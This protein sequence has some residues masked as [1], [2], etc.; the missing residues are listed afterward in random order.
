MVLRLIARSP[1]TGFVATVIPEKLTSQKLD[2]S[3][4]ASGPHDFAV[5]ISRARQLQLPR[6]P[7]PTAFR[8]DR[9]PPLLSGETRGE[10]PLICP[11]RQAEYFL[12]ADLTE[13]H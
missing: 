6:P 2:A 4:G 5:R 3:I 1:V 8:D 7:H 9:E 12:E 10:T 11:T 13:N